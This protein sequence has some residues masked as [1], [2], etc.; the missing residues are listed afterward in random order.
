MPWFKRDS[1]LCW[2][3]DVLTLYRGKV[4]VFSHPTR[5]TE[6]KSMGV[7]L[8]IHRQSIA[9]IFAPRCLRSLEGQNVH[10]S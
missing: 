2:Y 5:G 1:D 6:T 8:E 4:T 10:I 7:G 3:L 9:D